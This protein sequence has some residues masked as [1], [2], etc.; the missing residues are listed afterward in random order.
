MKLNSHKL[1][2]CIVKGREVSLAN[3]IPFID[4]KFNDYRDCYP[5][6][7]LCADG[8]VRCD[9]SVNGSVPDE[10][11]LASMIYSSISGQKKVNN[12]TASNKPVSPENSRFYTTSKAELYFAQNAEKR[13]DRIYAMA[14]GI[15]VGICTA[16]VAYKLGVK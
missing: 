5:L 1:L 11:T 7:M 3:I 6:A 13:S 2:K 8:Y 14:V 15:V 9:W 12:Y 4:T 10:Y 16:I